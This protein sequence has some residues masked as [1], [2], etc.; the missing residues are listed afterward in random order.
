MKKIK[1][2]IKNCSLIS[3]EIDHVLIPRIHN[4]ENMKE[5]FSRFGFKSLILIMICIGFIH[6]F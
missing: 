3:S 4:P 5:N 2:I 1:T 6:L